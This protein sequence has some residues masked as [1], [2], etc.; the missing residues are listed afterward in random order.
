VR[1]LVLTA[2]VLFVLA[3]G[4]LTALDFKHNGVTVVGV[5][6]LAVVVI[7]GVGVIGAALHQ[8]RNPRGK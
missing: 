7:C 2:A 8:P 3:L 4:V 5:L 6:G 1:F